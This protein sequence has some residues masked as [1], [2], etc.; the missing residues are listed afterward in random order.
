MV[1]NTAIA[2]KTGLPIVPSVS[3]VIDALRAALFGPVARHDDH[4]PI[5][6]TLGLRL[7]VND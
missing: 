7:A 4:V 1:Q 3:I 5:R 2:E 6:C